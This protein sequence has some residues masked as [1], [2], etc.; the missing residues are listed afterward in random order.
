MVCDSEGPLEIINNG[1][2]GLTFKCAERCED[3]YENVKSDDELTAVVNQVLLRD[4][5]S[6]DELAEK[7]VFFMKDGYPQEMLGK[8]YTNVRSK[9][10]VKYTA[11][12]YLAEYALLNK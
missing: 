12:R 4:A 1:E 8:A 6:I 9:Y 7:I 5:H 3:F 2:L 10:D 11:E